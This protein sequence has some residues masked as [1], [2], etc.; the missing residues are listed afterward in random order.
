MQQPE[1]QPPE[2]PSNNPSF[3]PPTLSQSRK[4]FLIEAASLAVLA[5]SLLGYGIY[6][7]LQVSPILI[8]SPSPKATDPADRPTPSLKAVLPGSVPANSP[9]T[10]DIYQRAPQA[11]TYYAENPQLSNSRR[12]IV[13]GNQRFC[14]KL[15]TGSITAAGSY[16]QV[17]VSSLSFHKDGVYIDATQ[18]KLKIDATATEIDDG[19]NV[20]QWLHKEAD[21]S[22]LMAEC[23]ASKTFYSRDAQGSNAS[24]N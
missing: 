11:G 19:R 16:Q 7:E 8:T 1:N 2:E 18:E 15:V 23:L 10:V 14:I 6:Q 21:N 24:S 4:T 5:I 12:E 22:G 9:A 3:D 17:T 13:S 20:W